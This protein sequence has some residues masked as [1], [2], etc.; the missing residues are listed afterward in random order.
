[1][2]D[3]TL[4]STPQV[5]RTHRR[6]GG[7]EKPGDVGSGV[8]HKREHEDFPVGAVIDTNYN[9]G[10]LSKSCEGNYGY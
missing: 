4:G 10:Q 9:D 5:K 7:N 2:N 8:Y 6:L 1:M 3:P